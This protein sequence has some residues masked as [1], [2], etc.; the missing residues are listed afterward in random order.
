[1]A[2]PEALDPPEPAIAAEPSEVPGSP[3]VSDV[4]TGSAASPDLLAPGAGDDWWS[5]L[6]ALDARRQRA[7]TERDPAALSD[8]LVPG[9]PAWRADSAL[10]AELRTQGVRPV[11]LA[12]HL[13]AIEEVEVDA[14]ASGAVDGSVAAEGD[15]GPSQGAGIATDRATVV[16]VDQRSAYT[17]ED[18]AGAVVQA[19]DA[20]GTQRWVVTL[21]RAVGLP[22]QW[23]PSGDPQSSA[24]QQLSDLRFDDTP[25]EGDDAGWRIVE[26]RSSS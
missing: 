22:S 4:S 3:G 9:S 2:S 10:I 17:L 13:V 26:I 6:G 16:L 21:A 14:A 23:P 12:T 15:P 5:I 11:G 20:S 8:Y 25:P 18:P 1:M 24:E 19:V 7:L